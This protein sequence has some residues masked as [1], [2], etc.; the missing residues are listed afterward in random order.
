MKNRFGKSLRL[1]T[2]ANLAVLTL[3]VTSPLL[4]EQATRTETTAGNAWK[5][6]VFLDDKE[7]GYHHFYMAES[8][9]TRRLKSVARFAYRLMFVRLFHYEHESNEIWNGDCLQSIDSRTDSNGEPFRVNGRR[10][11]G[12]FRL[13][14]NQGEESLPE[15]VMS[16]AYWNPAFLEQTSLLNTQDGEFLEVEFSEP[17]FEELE[18]GGGQRFSHRYHLVAGDLKLDLWYSLDREWL[19]LESEVRGGQKLRYVLVDEEEMRAGEYSLPT[20]I[21]LADSGSAFSGR[22]R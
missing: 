14:A 9:D 11:D 2:A 12:E 3:A 20:A 1:L 4:A 10:S 7:I 13:S 19:A 18:S 8:G 22:G 17:V 16:F 15:C 5:F 21:S 6:R